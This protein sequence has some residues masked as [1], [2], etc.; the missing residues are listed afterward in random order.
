MSEKEF[1]Y[2]SDRI[3]Q[4]DIA[5][6]NPDVSVFIDAS[7][8]SGKST[9]VLEDLCEYARGKG[10]KILLFENRK[11]NRIQF[12]ERVKAQGKDDVVLVQTYQSL[13]PNKKED[14][15]EEDTKVDLENYA[16]IVCDECHYFLDDS[17]FNEFT[18]VSYRAILKARKPVK[19][20]MSAT[21]EA[22]KEQLKKDGVKLKVYKITNKSPKYHISFRGD[23]RGAAVKF[24]DDMIKLQKKTVMFVNSI[25]TLKKLKE[26]YGSQ[27]IA[28]CSEQN[29]WKPTKKD[30]Q[31][32]EEMIHN[33]GKIPGDYLILAI[34]SVLY[35]GVD[36]WDED[37]HTVY[38]E[39]M[40]R[41]KICQALGRIRG[42][43]E[44]SVYFLDY[45]D[46]KI[47]QAQKTAAEDI[48][49]MDILT[50]E[51]KEYETLKPY[52]NRYIVGNKHLELDEDTDTVR[53]NPMLYTY[54]HKAIA[55]YGKIIKDGY[56]SY[57]CKEFGNAEDVKEIDK[58][59]RINDCL[60]RYDYTAT[61]K[62]LFGKQEQKAFTDELDFH[63][64]CGTVART[65]KTINAF[66]EECGAEYRIYGY[67]T[68][69]RKKGRGVVWHVLPTEEYNRKATTWAE[70]VRDI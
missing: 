16:Y 50:Y 53:Y 63:T 68:I 28:Y 47:Q 34:T 70:R 11:P 23:C 9:F 60:A 33:G 66:L 15:T 4:E 55:E 13:E 57:V 10:Q 52:F 21:G 19:I 69:R 12:T 45:K 59:E 42:N 31:A 56:K 5:A 30:K 25:S 26:K 58:N 32:V 49:L 39:F 46:K 17:P 44:M 37:V 54:Q 43:R 29:D 27:V 36:I 7:T 24:A 35:N 38:I 14:G 22:I 51:G 61:G 65:A 20:Y 40:E 2:V 6:W 8:G 18:K 64:K 3:S 1:V 41:D 67:P 48:E 62:E